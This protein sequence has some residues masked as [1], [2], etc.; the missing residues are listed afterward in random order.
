MQFLFD[1]WGYS[2]SIYNLSSQLWFFFKSDPDKI[3]K[4]V[5]SANSKPDREKFYYHYKRGFMDYW[6]LNKDKVLERQK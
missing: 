1:A 5:T 4:I 2:C 6:K 3:E